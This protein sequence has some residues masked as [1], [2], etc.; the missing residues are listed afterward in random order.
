MQI[1]LKMIDNITRYGTYNFG[2]GDYDCC[3]DYGTEIRE[4][5]NGE[6]IKINDLLEL[7]K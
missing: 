2:C 5:K 7:L 4:I 3:G 6:F 1:T